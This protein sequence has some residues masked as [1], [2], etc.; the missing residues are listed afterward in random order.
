MNFKKISMNLIGQVVSFLCSIGISFLLTPFIIGNLG[1]ETYGFVGLANNFISYI[2]LFT[3][4]MNGM[5][6]RYITVEYSKKN[7]EQ[8]SGYFTTALFAQVVLAVLLF[9]PMM[10]L[11]GKVDSVVNIS[12]EIVPDVRI[13]WT[14]IF[15][16]FLLG[17]P[18]AGFGTATFA[19]NRL[20]ISAAISVASNLLRV[21]IL[22]VTFA[23]FP[24][25]V[26]YVG[27]ASICSGMFSIVCNYICKRKMLP[28]VKC[29]KEYFDF[30]YI[31]NLLVVG[32]WNSL[33]RLQQILITGLD[34]LLTNLFVSSVEMGLLSVAKTLP[35]QISTLI[36][37]VSSAFDPSMT[38]AYGEGDMDAFI[39]QTKMS[40]KLSGFLCSAP[41]IGVVCFGL[42]FYSLW[43]P[44][45]SEA[46]L[47]KVQICAVLTLLPQ[48]FSVYIFPLYTVNT[49]TTKLK[50]PVLLSIAIGITNVII[51]YILLKL[52]NLGV[53]AVAGVSSILWILRIFLFVPP[54]AAWTLQLKWSTFYGPLLRGVVNVAVLIGFMGLVS[55]FV[56]ASSWLSLVLICVPVGVIGYVIAFLLIFEKSDRR[57]AIE[58]LRR[59]FLHK[60]KWERK[61]GK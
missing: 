53:Y 61:M 19:K 60:R 59:R 9:I 27:L 20:D 41:I 47:L 18:A 17:L 58:M 52:T 50:T 1:Q 5:L 57:S 12:P 37:T 26:W 35:T 4:A 36:G 25:R 55:R 32:I 22:L 24:A 8:A 38:I 46:D 29:S 34:L 54:Y 10:L 39:K 15:L 14:L 51:V 33:N 30:R 16:S 7:Y 31:K 48:V 3:V 49:I 44:S 28:E 6:S 11:A 45:L 40:M 56:W 2:T 21:M 43:V 23:F 13:L 42:N